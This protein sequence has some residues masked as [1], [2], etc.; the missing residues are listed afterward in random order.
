MGAST[1]LYGFLGLL[2]AFDLARHYTGDTWA[3]VA[4]LGVWFA[5]SLPVYMYFNPAW[6]HAHS[7]FAVAL[8]L[9]YWQRTRH[10]R[11]L[12]QWLVLGLAAGLMMNIY[13]PNAILM[14]VPAVEALADYYR[15]RPA[16]WGAFGGSGSL[17]SAPFANAIE[18][19]YMTDPI[20]R[21]SETMAKC[22]ATFLATS[23]ERT[24][25]DG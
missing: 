7:A 14:I 17:D 21:A 15:T 5:S 10:Q 22:A 23:P 19:F 1:V 18:N 8:F 12:R 4:T 25:T 2:M 11:S 16:R 24:G 9:W 20:S 6:S 13:Y 3:F